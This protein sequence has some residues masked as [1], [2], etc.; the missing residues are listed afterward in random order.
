M[1][2]VRFSPF[3]LLLRF[4][5]IYLFCSTV[6]NDTT[7]IINDT[8]K[9]V[10]ATQPILASSPHLSDKGSDGVEETMK[11]VDYVATLTKS[12]VVEV[13]FYSSP[14]SSLVPSP[15][16]VFTYSVGDS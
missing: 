12:K 3:L 7:K 15:L 4:F 6:I 14:P 8:T 1:R 9:A 2:T 5:H 10:L 13:T 11:C 16:F